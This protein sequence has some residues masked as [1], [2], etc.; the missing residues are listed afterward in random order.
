MDRVGSE[1]FLFVGCLI[2][3]W[4][5]FPAERPEPRRYR[6]VFRLNF[7]SSYVTREGKRPAGRLGELC[8]K[9]KRAEDV[10]EFI[11]DP[12]V[13]L[14]LYRELQVHDKTYEVIGCAIEERLLA[15][16]QSRSDQEVLGWPPD[17]EETSGLE[18]LKKRLLTKPTGPAWSV[19][20]YD[21]APVGHSYSPVYDDVLPGNF[22]EYAHQLNSSGLF[23]SPSVAAKFLA[24][25]QT[26]PDREP[27]HYYVY[28][29][30]APPMDD[31]LKR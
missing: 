19:L 26:Y 30:S 22:P 14:T 12:A 28:E 25:Y 9:M 11:I 8:A 29:V 20:G 4:L 17:D 2:V 13:A 24:E 21:I 31:L 5:A 1:G 23:A 15:D 3:E 7:A 18:S 6:G 16:L 27:G 10:L